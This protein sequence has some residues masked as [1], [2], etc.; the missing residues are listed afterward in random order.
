MKTL[1]NLL[2][3][4]LGIKVAYQLANCVTTYTTLS[5]AISELKNISVYLFLAQWFLCFVG[6]L[7]IFVLY[8]LFHR[9]K[10]MPGKKA[11]PRPHKLFFEA[12]AWFGFALPFIIS[13]VILGPDLFHINLPPISSDIGNNILNCEFLVFVGGLV[14]CVLSLFGIR[15]SRRLAFWIAMLGIGAN[16][17]IPFVTFFMLIIAGMGRNC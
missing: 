1:V 17:V 6:L 8:R 15:D 16:I 5:A 13:A 4:S 10:T 11:A 7:I 14:L 12:V 9:E 2:L 3:I